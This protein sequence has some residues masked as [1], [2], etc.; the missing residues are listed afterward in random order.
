MI[1]LPFDRMRSRH[2][3]HLDIGIPLLL[4]NS[5]SLYMFIDLGA[6]KKRKVRLVRRIVEGDAYQHDYKQPRQNGGL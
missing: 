1:S 6:R 5:T 3:Q 2:T 4:S